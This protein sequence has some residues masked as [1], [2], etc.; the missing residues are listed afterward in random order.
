MLNFVVKLTAYR[1]K[2]CRMKNHMLI[3]IQVASSLFVNKYKIDGGHV[4]I[5]YCLQISYI[6]SYSTE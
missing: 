3:D 4:N 5:G 6:S 1:L 2:N